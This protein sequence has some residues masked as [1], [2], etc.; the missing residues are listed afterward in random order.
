MQSHVLQEPQYNLIRLVGL[1]RNLFQ[2]CTYAD[3]GDGWTRERL[4]ALKLPS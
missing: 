2:P 4:A 1:I 3:R